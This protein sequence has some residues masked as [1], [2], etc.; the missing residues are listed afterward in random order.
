MAKRAAAPAVGEPPPFDT[1]H[2]PRLRIRMGRCYELAGI[3]AIDQPL[4]SLV[5][6]EV[7]T[8]DGG[9]IGHAWLE[10]EGWVYDTSH[11]CSFTRQDYLDRYH[12]VEFARWQGGKEAAQMM[13]ARGH[14]GPWVGPWA[15]KD[16]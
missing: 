3:A 11:G 4:W 7:D 15:D 12:A 14:Y 13:R 5:H 10:R 9:R 16:K 2:N 6:G 8:I 1:P